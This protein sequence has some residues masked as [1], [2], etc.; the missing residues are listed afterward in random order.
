[1]SNNKV[2]KKW[3]GSRELYNSLKNDGLLDYWT[4]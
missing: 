4:H 3:R 1:M 2:F